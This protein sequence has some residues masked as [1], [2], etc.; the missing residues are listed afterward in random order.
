M[1]KLLEKDKIELIIEYCKERFGIKN[2]I[3]ST[4]NWYVGS[5]NRIYI[6]TA[7]EIDRIKPES[8]GLCIFR[9][10]KT[11]KPTTNFIQ[12]F[13]KR[14][15]KNFIILD[16]KNSLDFCKGSDLKIETH[17]KPGFVS[18]KYQDISLG[19]GHW[20]GVILKNQIPKSKFC[21]INFV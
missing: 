6:T 20:N 11:P 2:E 4:Y 16:K 8:I 5:K 1:L 3:L 9:L 15:T 19:C 17:L 10:D 18:I 13:G 12:L 14:I 21:K 7:K